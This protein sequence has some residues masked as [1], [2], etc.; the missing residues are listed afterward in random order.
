MVKQEDRPATVMKKGGGIKNSS[1]LLV[2]LLAL[3]SISAAADSGVGE[4][5]LFY[6]RKIKIKNY[7]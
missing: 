7:F 1:F 4:V 5:R 3:S 6:S 2:V